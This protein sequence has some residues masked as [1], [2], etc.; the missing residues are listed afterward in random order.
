[1]SVD[2]KGSTKINIG[3]N[4][5]GRIGRLI[6]R[7]A[8]QLPS[9]NCHITAINDPFMN[10]ESMAY[11]LKHDSVHGPFSL[12]V[13]VDENDLLV[14]DKRIRVFSCTN[15]ADIPWG[16]NSSDYICEASGAFT[17]AAKAVAHLSNG[18]SKVIISAPTKDDTPMFVMGVNHKSYKSHMNVV[19]NASCTTNC[20]APLLKV[21]NDSFGIEEV[22]MTTIHAVTATQ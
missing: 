12:E 10:A 14:D 7:A 20:L 22:L 9:L 16:Q 6:A 8:F 5:F 11:L 18:A 4:G 3:I 1:M 2:E 17:T 19:S 13:K 15:P 21:I